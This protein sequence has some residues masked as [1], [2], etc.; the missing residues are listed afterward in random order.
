MTEM[1][2]ALTPS[3]S[4]RPWLLTAIL[5]AAL[6]LRLGLVFGVR[7]IGIHT[8][9]ERDYV[10]LAQSLE[11]DQRFGYESGSTSMR[12]PLYPAFVA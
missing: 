11:A 3:R 12:P 8:D 5:A 10:K 9:D 1:S 2:S 4:R 6:L 7:D